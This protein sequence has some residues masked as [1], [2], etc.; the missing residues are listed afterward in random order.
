MDREDKARALLQLLNGLLSILSPLFPGIILKLT[1]SSTHFP[2][3]EVVCQECSLA[4]VL[5]VFGLLFWFNGGRSYHLEGP[6]VH[7]SAGNEESY[8]TMLFT[9]FLVNPLESMIFSMNEDLM[10]D[11]MLSALVDYI[12]AI[13]YMPET[14]TS[15]VDWLQAYK[16]NVAAFISSGN[17]QA[18]RERISIAYEASEYH[19]G[20]LSLN[21]VSSRY[22][23][24]FELELPFVPVKN[25]DIWACDN[26]LAGS[27]CASMLVT[28]KRHLCSRC[29]PSFYVVYR[30]AAEQ[31]LNGIGRCRNVEHLYEGI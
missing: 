8:M 18:N 28:P 7:V 14:A 23:N 4:K 20:E 13:A 3:F 25:G 30:R 26:C 5:R 1:T 22:A 2:L 10:T 15:F 16:A 6:A 27:V 9:Q 12:V 11:D 17:L 31:W 19:N 29:Y 24:F 21:E